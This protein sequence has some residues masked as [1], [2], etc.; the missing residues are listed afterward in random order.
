MKT[1]L[2]SLG[3]SLDTFIFNGAFFCLGQPISADEFGLFVNGVFGN[4]YD[5][6]IQPRPSRQP[7]L[8]F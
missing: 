2:L 4:G 1:R 3:V 5:L 8:H 7:W 6:T